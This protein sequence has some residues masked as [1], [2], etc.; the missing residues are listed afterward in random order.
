MDKPLKIENRTEQ[1]TES[2]S[3][4]AIGPDIM[5]N[6]TDTSF[7]V[8]VSARS[9]AT[10]VIGGKHPFPSFCAHPVFPEFRIQQHR[11]RRIEQGQNEPMEPVPISLLERNIL[12]KCES[13]LRMSLCHGRLHPGFGLQLVRHLERGILVHLLHV[14]IDRRVR[15]MKEQAVEPRPFPGRG[16]PTMH[17]LVLGPVV[18]SS[19]RGGTGNRGTSRRARSICRRPRACGGSQSRNVGRLR[20]ASPGSASRKVSVISSSASMMNIQSPVA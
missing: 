19:G 2:P 20:G 15:V 11:I 10:F 8:Y 18:V 4:P 16:E 6:P 9:I 3:C 1:S 5:Q 7:I 14:R 17:F 13:G 12:R